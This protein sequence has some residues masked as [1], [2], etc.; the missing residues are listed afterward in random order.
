MDLKAKEWKKRFETVWGPGGN[1]RAGS[2]GER[3][4]HE[5]ISPSDHQ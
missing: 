3:R 4:S 5:D 2:P 1:L